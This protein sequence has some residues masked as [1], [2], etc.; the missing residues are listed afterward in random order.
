MMKEINRKN[1]RKG[2]LLKNGNWDGDF[3]PLSN[4]PI[5][6]TSW[7]KSIIESIKS[8]YDL[9]NINENETIAKT[10]ID[11]VSYVNSETNECD[12]R[13]EARYEVTV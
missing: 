12:I 3:D 11:R 6:T 2:E 7:Y 8:N 9:E 1:H 10:S 5:E 4:I 13:W